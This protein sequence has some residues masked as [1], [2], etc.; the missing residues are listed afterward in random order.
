MCIIN[1][2]TG[3]VHLV[4]NLPSHRKSNQ[5][6]TKFN[7]EKFRRSRQKANQEVLIWTFNMSVPLYMS[8][9]WV[10]HFP[11]V[12]S[13]IYSECIINKKLQLCTGIVTKTSRQFTLL[14]VLFLFAESTQVSFAVNL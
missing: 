13:L 10:K 9:H 1:L 14:F 8:V 6:Y 2:D 12:N 4:T 7:E 11:E 3:K 5:N